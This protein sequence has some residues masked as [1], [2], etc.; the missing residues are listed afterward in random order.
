MTAGC[1]A[2]SH[3][4]SMEEPYW[5]LIGREVVVEANNTTY[6]GILIEIGWDAV[7]LESE[8]GWL[9]IPMESVSDVYL[10]E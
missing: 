6:R 4:S 2:F 10:E 3:R 8:L 1:Q 5:E 7:H 9:M